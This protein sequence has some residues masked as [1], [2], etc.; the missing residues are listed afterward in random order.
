MSLCFGLP[1]DT[2]QVI[3]VPFFTVLIGATKTFATSYS[4]SNYTFKCDHA[5]HSFLFERFIIRARIESLGMGSHFRRR[6][7][8]FVNCRDCNIFRPCLH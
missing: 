5:S 4:A 6:A 7:I 3:Q 1:R 2:L 8:P